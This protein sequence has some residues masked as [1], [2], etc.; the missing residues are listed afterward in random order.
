MKKKNALL[1]EQ[2]KKPMTRNHAKEL[3]RKSLGFDILDRFDINISTLAKKPVSYFCSD[4][5]SSRLALGF[6]HQSSGTGM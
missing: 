5:E 1:I 2:I 3:V 4:F 6:D